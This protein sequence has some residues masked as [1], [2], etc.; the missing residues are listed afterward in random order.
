MFCFRRPNQYTLALLVTVGTA[1]K[2]SDFAPAFIGNSNFHQLLPT[3]HIPEPFWHPPDIATGNSEVYDHIYIWLY[4]ES[5]NSTSQLVS[6]FVGFAPHP[7]SA[8]PLSL[9]LI[10]SVLRWDTAMPSVWTPTITKILNKC[11]TGPCLP[12]CTSV[13]DDHRLNGKRRSMQN[14]IQ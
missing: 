9:Y 11:T 2:H 8:I 1:L 4:A 5:E 10:A 3:S 6:I 13:S 12:T 14:S 7:S